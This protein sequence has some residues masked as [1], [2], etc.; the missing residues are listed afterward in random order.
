MSQ[1]LIDFTKK[2]ENYTLISDTTERAQGKSHGDLSYQVGQKHFFFAFLDPQPNGAG[3]V[4]IHTPLKL[5]LAPNQSLCLTAKGLK[6][7]PSVFQLIINTSASRQKHFS[8]QQTF[9][10]NHEKTTFRL[11][12]QAFSATYRGKPLADAPLLDTSDIQSIGI[13][14]I[15]RDKVP[16]QTFQKGLYGLALY[17]LSVCEE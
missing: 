12:L 4:S 3:F 7:N 11:P 15:G 1:T 6:A 10:A 2:L 14:I 16:N 5:T 8:Y 13:R 17:N 9:I